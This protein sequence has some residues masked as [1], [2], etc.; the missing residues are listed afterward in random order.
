MIKPEG[1]I[2]ILKKIKYIEKNGEKVKQ[3]TYV[4]KM[5]DGSE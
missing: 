1:C 4:F 3:V 2:K 5:K